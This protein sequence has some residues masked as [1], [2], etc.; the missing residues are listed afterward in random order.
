MP[1]GLFLKAGCF[2]ETEAV[3]GH[4]QQKTQAR[5]LLYPLEGRS[6][7][8][9]ALWSSHSREGWNEVLTNVLTDHVAR[10]AA[11]FGSEANPQHRFEQFLGALN[12]QLAT[13]VREGSWRVPIQQFHALVGIACDD[14]M[15][16]SGNGDLT[17]LFLHRKPGGR[18]QVFNLFRSIQTGQALPSW[19]KPFAVVLDGDLHVGDVLCLSNKELTRVVPPDDLHSSLPTLP[20][21]GAA[22]RIRQWFSPHTDLAILILQAQELE[23]NGATAARPLSNVSIEHLGATED[24]TTELLEDQRPAVFLAAQRWCRAIMARPRPNALRHASWMRAMM[25]GPASAGRFVGPSA[26]TTR[27]VAASRE[28]RRAILQGVKHGFNRL[29]P[30]RKYLGLAAVTTFFL[31]AIGLMVLNRAQA[32][33]AAERAYTITVERAE[34]KRD[35]AAAAV[36]YKD[37]TQAK[38]LYAEARI[39]AAEL[40]S[41][42]PERQENRTRLLNEI[43]SA[44]NQLRHITTI[45]DP[46]LVATLPLT[47]A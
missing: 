24:R 23:R 40:V 9:F 5:S 3:K 7:F 8:T 28:T 12:E 45:P 47:V 14:H 16:L 38:N 19:E 1:S 6:G 43:D 2:E 44:L 26:Q 17:A 22:E 37:E 10:L 11:S 36:I 46:P 25:R 34:E 27:R 18:Y 15:F 39:A 31:F 13:H 33:R 21:T 32:G 4:S 41:D 35:A 20:P 42:T 29:P 30:R